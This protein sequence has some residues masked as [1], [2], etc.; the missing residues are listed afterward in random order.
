MTDDII[1]HQIIILVSIL[2]SILCIYAS[3]I[4]IIG[5]LFSILATVLTVVLGTN[6]LRHVGK[7]SL[8]TGV[9]SIVYMLTAVGLVS[10]ISGLALSFTLDLNI[11]FPIFSLIIAV[12][13]GF[14]ISMMCKYIFKIQV[15]IL[16]KSFILIA[17]STMLSILAM[18]TLIVSSFDSILIYRNV[19]E[20]GLVILFMIITVMAIQ[21]PYNSC[22][23]PNEDQIRTL[24]LSLANAFLMLIIVSLTSI[25]FNSYWYVYLI[26]SILG[27]IVFISK[28]FKY[29]KQQAAS[30]RWSGLWPLN[31]GE[32]V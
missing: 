17:L 10:L 8:G 2:G 32:D 13:L 14:I 18:S 23:G 15:E 16:T 31:D 22:M 25:L 27:W 28:Y 5:G 1:P 19:V 12:I 20:N 26:V 3:C 7:Y 11:L 4:S 21:N 9:P 30:V 6:T 29:T 24:S